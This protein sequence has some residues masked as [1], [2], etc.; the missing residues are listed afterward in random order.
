MCIY[1]IGALP[2]SDISSTPF[3]FPST[4][5]TELDLSPK[6]LQVRNTCDAEVQPTNLNNFVRR[7]RYPILNSSPQTTTSELIVAATK[8]MATC[9]STSSISLKSTGSVDIQ[10]RA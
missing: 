8:R 7:P 10:M 9:S 5:L 4:S 1:L 2:S 3:L 6:P